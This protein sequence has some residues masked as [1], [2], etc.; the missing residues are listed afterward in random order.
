MSLTVGVPGIRTVTVNVTHGALA[1]TTAADVDVAV[2]DVDATD[3]VVALRVPN[4]LEARVVL[5]GVT[6][7][8]A[9]TVRFRFT[10]PSAAAAAGQVL[11]YTIGIIRQP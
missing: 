2:A 4:T 3:V 9:D 1:A 11:A 5:Q 7:P 8:T 6:I 10:N